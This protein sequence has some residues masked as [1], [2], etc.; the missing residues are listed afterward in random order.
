MKK[1]ELVYSSNALLC[2]AGQVQLDCYYSSFIR[3][4]TPV[5]LDCYENNLDPFHVLLL[6]LPSNLI[7]S[8]LQRESVIC[9]PLSAAWRHLASASA[10]PAPIF[11]LSQQI[12]KRDFD[13]PTPRRDH[14]SLMHR[15]YLQLARSDPNPLPVP[16]QDE[17]RDLEPPVKEGLTNDRADAGV[18]RP[19][20]C[21]PVGFNF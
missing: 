3:V 2:V 4:A 10:A 6:A 9:F 8:S 19:L 12:W 20:P 13:P 15:P 7:V 21:R 17:C 1:T 18:A 14:R 16:R 11:T 5:K